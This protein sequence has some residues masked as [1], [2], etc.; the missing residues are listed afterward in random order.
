VAKGG[1]TITANVASSNGGWGVNA[2]AGSIDG[3]A[4]V[5]MANRESGQC[6]GVV[7]RVDVAPPDTTITDRPAG[8]TTATSASFAFTG[9]DDSS[10]PSALA[11]ECRL[12]GQDDDFVQC[13]SPQI[14]TGLISG[15]HTFEVRAIDLA[16]NADTTPARHTWV[17]SQ[18]GACTITG[19]IGADSL[20]GTSER[21]V[22]CGLGGNDVIDGE[23]GADILF[24]GPGAD[25]LSGGPGDDGLDGGAGPDTVL[26][27]SAASGV[28]VSLMAGTAWGDGADSLAAIERVVGSRF[29]DS[30]TGHG[31]NN[32]LQGGAGNDAV[33]GRDGNDTVNGGAGDDTLSGGLGDDRLNGGS[34][35]DSLDAGAGTDTCRGGETLAKCEA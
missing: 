11:F 35:N 31:G 12:E 1:H 7:C 9:S 26:Y 22:I 33:H 27:T 17:I 18:P 14:Y 10:P 23:E 19:T 2:A 32:S 20:V 4:N 3:G 13:S 28:T 29:V 25:R 34:G 16:G 5:A 15:T 6:T 30:I 21:D 8:T 24:G